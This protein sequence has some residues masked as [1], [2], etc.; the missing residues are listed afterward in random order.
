MLMTGLM[1]QAGH[2]WAHAGGESQRAWMQAMQAE[3][4][5]LADPAMEGGGQVFAAGLGHSHD[6]DTDPLHGGL[7]S[8]HVHS[9]VFIMP[10][11]VAHGLGDMLAAKSWPLTARIPLSPSESP[12]RPPRS[13]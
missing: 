2:A 9:V 10:S 11:G 1:G 8:D 13:V 4:A 5:W 7:A 6:D 3:Q 12:D